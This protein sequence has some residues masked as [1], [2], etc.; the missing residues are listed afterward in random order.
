MRTQV[1]IVG[2]GPAGLLLGQLLH[3]AGIDNVVLE[4]RSPE[5]VLG[6][7]R[8]GVLE[9]TTVGLLEQAGVAARLHRDGLVHRGTELAFDGR[10]H[11]LDFERLVGRHVTV[12]GQTEVTRDLLAARTGSGRRTIHEASEVSLHGFDG[13]APSVRWR[14]DGEEHV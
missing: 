7:I 3:V 4:Q 13:A 2:G 8:A 9:D 6:R 14:K 11:R 5:Y 1:A 12:Y 10:L